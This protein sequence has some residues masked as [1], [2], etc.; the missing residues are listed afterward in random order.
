M[1]V[2]EKH[3]GFGFLLSESLLWS[4]FPIITAVTVTTVPPI[5]TAGIATLL[6]VPLFLGVMLAKKERF[7]LSRSAFIN[8]LLST[9]YIGILY[10]GLS[11]IGI[12]H[13]SAGNASILA[14]ME[15]FFSFILFGFLFKNERVN[16]KKIIGALFMCVGAVFILGIRTYQF[17]IGDLLIIAATIWTPL[18]NLYQKNARGEVSSAYIMLFRSVVSG[19]FLICLGYSIEE[20]P[21]S[22]QLMNSLPLLLINGLLLLGLSKIFWIEAIHRLP[23]TKTVLIQPVRPVFT[24]LFILILFGN[25]P[26]ADQFIALVPMAIGAF[27]VL[28]K[29]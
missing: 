28:Q 26:S 16:G 18:G 25:P 22:V 15:I 17:H 4:L 9:L 21:T 13:T 7:K 14:L 3:K 23:I 2:A 12:K 24:L 20:L 5:L 19:V 10:Y 11:F 27:L 29:G 8:L 1:R 6:S